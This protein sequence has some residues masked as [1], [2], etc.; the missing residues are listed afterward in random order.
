MIGKNQKQALLTINDRVT[1][2]LFM[3]KVSNKLAIEIEKKQ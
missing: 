3:G 2:M 1:G